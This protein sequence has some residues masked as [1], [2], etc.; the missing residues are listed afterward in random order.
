MS[1][2]RLDC[3]RSLSLAEVGYP[4]QC[5][6]VK[7]NT[8]NSFTFGLDDR[9]AGIAY[10]SDEPGATPDA[11]MESRSVEGRPDIDRYTSMFTFF[12]RPID[13]VPD[14]LGTQPHPRKGDHVDG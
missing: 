8:T 2:L 6:S 3:S 11:M 10:A 14:M 7:T 9:R 13:E 5:P 4:S 1:P 12:P